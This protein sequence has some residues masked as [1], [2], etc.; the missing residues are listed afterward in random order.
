VATSRAARVARH[1]AASFLTRLALARWTRGGDIPHV[2]AAAGQPPRA[3]WYGQA[4]RGFQRWLE[5]GG[6]HEAAAA[7][8]GTTQGGAVQG[9]AAA[10]EPD[11]IL[12][13]AVRLLEEAGLAC[14]LRLRDA[15]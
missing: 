2:F 8:G 15:K 6:F 3:A 14:P 1:H 12:D 9:G 13:R 4:Q 11:A 7:Q 10:M 5:A